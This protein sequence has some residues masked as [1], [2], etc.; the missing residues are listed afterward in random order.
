MTSRVSYG[1]WRLAG[2]APVISSTGN[3]GAAGASRVKPNFGSGP[4]PRTRSRM[5]ARHVASSGILYSQTPEMAVWLSAPPRVCTSVTSPT[6][7]WT[8][9]GPARNTE[10]VPSTIRLSSD[11]MGK[12]APP[13]TQLPMI[14]AI[15]GTPSADIRALL[16]KMR[17]K[18]SRSG[19]ISSC[20]GRKTPAESTK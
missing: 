11:M 13:A 12:Y 1:V 18:W 2:N 19:K 7:A 5:V 8:R 4:S 17:P 6:A 10:P 20:I 9:N 16:R 14:A 3:A 15:W